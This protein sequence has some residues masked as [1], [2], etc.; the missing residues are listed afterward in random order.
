VASYLDRAARPP[1]SAQQ[2]WTE[3]VQNVAKSSTIVAKLATWATNRQ[4]VTGTE[5]AKTWKGENAWKGRR[6]SS[7]SVGEGRARSG[8]CV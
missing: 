5:E 4:S 3:E 8:R 6:Y 1:G 7:T 2:P